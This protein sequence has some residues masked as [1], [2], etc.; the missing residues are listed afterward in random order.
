MIPRAIRGG[1]ALLCGLFFPKGYSN[2][3]WLGAEV[4]FYVRIGRQRGVGRRF[5]AVFS[6]TPSRPPMSD[7][8]RVFFL[9]RK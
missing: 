2:M 6:V 5:P 1:V 3:R 4:P 7:F 9:R 8:F